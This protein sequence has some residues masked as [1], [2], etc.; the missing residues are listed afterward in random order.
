MAGGG[1]KAGGMKTVVMLVMVIITPE[2]EM[3]LTLPNEKAPTAA[4]SARY[5][6]LQRL[7]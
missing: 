7:Q 5:R 3:R 2:G 4:A 1:M 6:Y